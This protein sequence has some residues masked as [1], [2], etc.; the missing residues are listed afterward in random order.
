MDIDLTKTP[1]ELQLS[2]FAGHVDSTFVLD[3]DG[4]PLDLIL[5]EAKQIK[6]TPKG[7]GVPDIVRD[8]PFA[9]LFRG[10]NDAPLTQR[11][12]SMKH[13]VLG[14]FAL[15]LVPI[16]KDENGMVYESIYN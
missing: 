4:T 7:P 10:P 5:I 13:D 2:T 11:I 3:S 14:E 1:V 12:Y 16:D 6:G 9:L 8:E 15:F